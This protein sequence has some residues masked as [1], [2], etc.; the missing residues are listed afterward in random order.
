MAV[1]NKLDFRDHRENKE[2][3]KSGFLSLKLV[4]PK[5]P[6][7]KKKLNILAAILINYT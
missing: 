2:Y 5:A 6:A 3:A 7:F 4:C 1:T